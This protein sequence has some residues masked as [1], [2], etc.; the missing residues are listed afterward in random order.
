MP[1]SILP[2]NQDEKELSNAISSFFCQLNNLIS[3]FFIRPPPKMIVYLILLHSIILR[4]IHYG[5]I[6]YSL[7]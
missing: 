4:R 5:Q 6:F 3:K 7:S 1:T 2:Q